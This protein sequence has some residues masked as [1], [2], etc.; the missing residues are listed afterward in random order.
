L[1]LSDPQN[2]W[3]WFKSGETKHLEKF[4]LMPDIQS[5]VFENASIV[6]NGEWRM[7]NGEWR[8]ENG[9]WRME[10]GEWRMEN[11]EWRMENGEW[12]VES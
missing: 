11:G 12:G 10:N 9:E 1:T 7:E 6:H 5:N 2:V 3:G 8:M 4:F